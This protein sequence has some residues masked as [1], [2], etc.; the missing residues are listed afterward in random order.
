MRGHAFTA[1]ALQ[2]AC[3]L[4]EAEGFQC[5][6]AENNPGEAINGARPGLALQNLCGDRRQYYYQWPQ[7]QH[8]A[9]ERS[10]YLPVIPEGPGLDAIDAVHEI[11]CGDAGEDGA[12][13]AQLYQSGC[14]PG[15]QPFK[16]HW[17]AT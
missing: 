3:M 6:P 12:P 7:R 2:I 11:Q 1:V 10:Q 15:R 13:A 16:Q 8:A 4:D 5:Q 14:Q 17:Q 9:I